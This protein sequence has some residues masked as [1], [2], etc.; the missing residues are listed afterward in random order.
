MVAWDPP[1]HLGY[2]IVQGFPVRGYRADV[3][4]TPDGPGTIVTWT[5]TFDE[6]I[7]ATGR[8]M[9]V[10]LTQMIRRFASGAAAHA[11]RLHDEAN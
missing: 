9:A 5:A 3:R 10:V 4:L 11:G 8:L 2:T 6:K 1:H 7:P